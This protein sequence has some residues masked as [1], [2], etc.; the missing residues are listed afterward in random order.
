[1]RAFFWMPLCRSR[2]LALIGTQ[3]VSSTEEMSGV[4]KK[5]VASEYEKNDFI[6]I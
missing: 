3:E 2:V 6:T 5:T 1:M 4:M